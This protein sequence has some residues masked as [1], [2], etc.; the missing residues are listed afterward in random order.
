MTEKIVVGIAEEVIIRGPNGERQVKGRIDT[1]AKSSSID[2]K[3]AEELGIKPKTGTRWVRS[4][5]GTTVRQLADVDLVLAGVELR[6]EFTIIDRSSMR[7]PV[8]IGRRVLE[9]RF[10]VDP[11]RK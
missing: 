2:S 4:S 8:L 11:S 1:G 9:E 3:L 7:Y 10:L 5:H 6:S